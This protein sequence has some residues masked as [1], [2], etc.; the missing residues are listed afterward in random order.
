MSNRLLAALT[1]LSIGG[2]G[3]ALDLPSARGDASPQQQEAQ[4]RARG[5][6]LWA[7]RWG[8]GTKSC[9]DCHAS[10]PNKMRGARLKAYPKYDKAA[11][12][13]ITGQEKLRQ[14][15]EQK[16]MGTPFDL[17]SADL[18]A[19]EAFVATLR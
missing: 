10:G 6:A 9:A 14:M 8:A 7:Q 1:V 17:G 4:V 19:L 5:E 13:V 18:T 15:I 12:R 16:S 2:F 3:L 11:G